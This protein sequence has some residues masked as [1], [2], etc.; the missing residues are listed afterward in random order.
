MKSIT[1]YWGKQFG[2]LTKDG[3]T[4]QHRER[5]EWFL[6]KLHLAVQAFETQ[7]DLTALRT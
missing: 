3:R 4:G 7:G 6:F 1:R 2:E 5:L